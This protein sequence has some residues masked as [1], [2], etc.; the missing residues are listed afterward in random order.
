[1][2]Q[3]FPEVLVKTWMTSVLDTMTFLHAALSGENDARVGVA[4]TGAR[5]VMRIVHRPYYVF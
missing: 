3:W 2:E 1:M 5:D 4:N